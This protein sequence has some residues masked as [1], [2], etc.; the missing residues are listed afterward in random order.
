MLAADPRAKRAKITPV[1]GVGARSGAG[2][3]VRLRKSFG[4]LAVAVVCGV[5][6]FAAALADVKSPHAT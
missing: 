5:A 4:Y 2:F 3:F 1:G 6:L